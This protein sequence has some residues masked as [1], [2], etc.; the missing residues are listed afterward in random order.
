M[1]NQKTFRVF[2]SSTFND[3]QEER[4]ILQNEVFPEIKSY[5]KL[6][7]YDF[8]PI[9]LRWGVGTEAGIDHKTMEICIKEVEKISNYPKPNFLI[10]LGN[11]YG[12]V[13]VPSEI[14]NQYFEILLQNISDI[15]KKLLH[16][17]YRKDENTIPEAYVLQPIDKIIM[18]STK[19]QDLWEK[20]EK[21]LV[22]IIIRHKHIFPKKLHI[23]KSATEQEIIKGVLEPATMIED[24]NE[25][26]LCMVRNIENINTVKG[27]HYVDADQTAL[28]DLKSRL[29]ICKT[30]K[31]EYKQLLAKLVKKENDLRPDKDYLEDYAI[32]VKNYLKENI[33]EQIKNLSS[34]TE[35]IEVQAHE[36]FM[37]ERTKVFVGRSDI[38]SSVQTY[39]A[40]EEITSPFVIFG[41]SGVGKSALMAKIIRELSESYKDDATLLYRF[42]GISEASSQPKLLIDTLII[43]L[44]EI[45]GTS[46]KDTAKDYSSTVN[47]FIALLN[48]YTKNHTKRLII[49]IDAL[50]QFEVETNLEWIE[51]VLPEHIKIIVST[52]PS[53]YGNYYDILKTK[54]PESQIHRL[55]KLDVSDAEKIVF[56]WLQ[57]HHKKLTPVQLTHILTLFKHNGLALYLKIIFDQALLWR[58][59]DDA[60]TQLQDKNLSDAIRSFF[61]GLIVHK[62]HSKMLVEHTLGYLSASKNGLSESEIT[63]IL[64]S[65]HIVMQDI[66][67]PFHKLPLNTDIH[68]L[69]AAVWSRLYYDLSKY[70]T[71]VE[72]DGIS[73]MNFYHRKIKENSRD[74]YYMVNREFFHTNLLEYF[75]NQPLIYKKSTLTNLRKLT[76]LPYHCIH[77]HSY[78]KF[79]DLY[80]AQFIDE[81]LKNSQKENMLNELFELS[82]DLLDNQDINTDFKDELITKIIHALFSF[83]L[84][85]IKKTSSSIISV[86]DI[87]AI[88][89]FR[90]DTRFYEKWLSI[91]SDI[92]AL[93]EKYENSQV[94][95]SYA[96]AFKARK[97]NILRREAKLE[98]AANIY[99]TMISNGDIK[100]LHNLEQSTILYDVGTIAYLR[101]DPEKALTFLKES[102]DI[103]GNLNEGISKTM[104]MVKYAQVRFV[105]YEDYNYFESVLDEAFT[106]FWKFRLKNLSARRF[107]K[108]IYALYF[109]LYYAI[110]DT[111]K[112]TEYLDKFKSDTTS[113]YKSIYYIPSDSSRFEASQCTG[114]TP[115]EARI[116]MLKGEYESAADMFDRYLHTFMDEKDRVTLEFIAKEYMDYMIALKM[117][118]RMD[119]YEEAYAQVMGLPD[120]PIN[121]IWKQ[122]IKKM[123]QGK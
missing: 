67:N 119:D 15:E 26:V 112:A 10:M 63:E 123:Y 27:S 90:T 20:E 30:P 69:P 80:D 87:H 75:W 55:V 110:G 7:G 78:S 19:Y 46:S 81:K 76:E 11:R 38:L 70:L 56:S 3:L 9:D 74:Y 85:N 51:P 98:E 52:L 50:D 88:Y 82:T 41:D 6:F 21:A 96:T 64:S 36:R 86:E 109:D 97:G 31:V 84:T 91:T 2:I 77:S 35:E 8:E 58:S 68:K 4:N 93:T 113:V 118:N 23:G 16:K 13:P 17:W 106:L 48:E 1:H 95:S 89:T 5:C 28:N 44:R 12:W 42:V 71:F 102:A 47:Q 24:G 105:Y 39:V 59:Y 49:I 103:A 40:D 107:V 33:S 108:N 117:S 60:F 65:D 79:I 37:T 116:K 61:I 43:Q 54:V 104:S 22:E 34:N 14:E 66:S 101:G 115:Y 94:L 25:H 122:R 83:L 72:F 120:E 29:Q 53:E 114:F 121:A 73:L 18:N 92:G 32:A 99:E 100:L 57:M 111:N 62:H 45:L